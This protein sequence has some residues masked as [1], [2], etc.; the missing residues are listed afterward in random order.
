M[1][2]PYDEKTAYLDRPSFEMLAKHF[3]IIPDES[4]VKRQG[5]NTFVYDE[6]RIRDLPTD[7]LIA[8]SPYLVIHGSFVFGKGYVGSYEKGSSLKRFIS[9]MR[10]RGVTKDSYLDAMIDFEFERMGEESAQFIGVIAHDIE[11]GNYMESKNAPSWARIM[12]NQNRKNLEKFAGLNEGREQ[13]FELERII[14]IDSPP[15]AIDYSADGRLYIFDKTGMLHEFT[16]GEKTNDW[17]V[18]YGFRQYFGGHMEAIFSPVFP[19]ISVHEGIMF[20]TNGDAL[21]RHDLEKEAA[22]TK[23]LQR[24]AG[25]KLT[26][27]AEQKVDEK[28]IFFHDVCIREGNVFVS[29]SVKTSIRY[30]LQVSGDE[31]NVVYQGHFPRDHGGSNS[32]QDLTLRLGFFNGGLYFPV[33]N[34]ISR[35]DGEELHE[36]IG[37]YAVEIEQPYDVD[38]LTKFAFGKD[39][40][41]ASGRA[42]DF[43]IHMLQFYRPVYGGEGIVQKG[44]LVHPTHFEREY[45]TTLPK[46]TGRMMQK[47]SITAHGDRFA[48]THQDFSRVFVY[49]MKE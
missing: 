36:M 12:I 1:E 42:R 24:H 30:V 26:K 23:Q 27:F 7:E 10:E 41:V 17:Q 20:L 47:L 32:L 19:G 14:K 8:L 18:R 44:S 22:E 46:N 31:F 11:G 40:M 25:N 5:Y 43:Q 39:F 38:P 13:P 35:Y 16:D 34:G 45:I 37:K 6:S 3:E 15:V 28:D 21:E 9:L 4:K 2:Y 29:A 49:K 33:D 48:F